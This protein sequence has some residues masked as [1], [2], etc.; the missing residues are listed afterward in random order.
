MSYINHF[1]IN[2]AKELLKNAEYE[3][4]TIEAIGGMSG[5]KS[6][7]AFNSAFKKITGYTPSE[8]KS[9]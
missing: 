3:H 1:R 4:Y 8:Y 7:S 9:K 2:S 5:F 6:K